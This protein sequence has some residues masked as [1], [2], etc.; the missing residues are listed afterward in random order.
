M[1]FL[2]RVVTAINK[3]MWK[4]TVL[5]MVYDN[6]GGP[7]VV[8][9]VVL[10]VNKHLVERKK[11]RKEKKKTTYQGTRDESHWQACQRQVLQNCHTDIDYHIVSKSCGPCRIKER[12]VKG[13]LE[14]IKWLHYTCLQELSSLLEVKMKMK[15]DVSWAKINVGRLKV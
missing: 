15:V 3:W 9:A 2:T 7:F 8:I 4:A 1:S 10:I 12:L 14:E 6:S 11:W 13:E 5:V